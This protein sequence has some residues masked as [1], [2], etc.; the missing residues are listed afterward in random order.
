MVSADKV[1][2][3]IQSRA[4]ISG[5]WRHK[6]WF[7]TSFIDEWVFITIH[8]NFWNK[9]CDKFINNLT[10]PRKELVREIEELTREANSDS[11]G[12]WEARIEVSEPEW[13]N[14]WCKLQ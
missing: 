10:S 13:T 12:D 9:E 3:I 2:E 14:Y 4:N 5:T 1:W 7:K 6:W 11:W 8:E